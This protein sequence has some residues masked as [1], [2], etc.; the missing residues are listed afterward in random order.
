[1]CRLKD[2]KVDR[3]G[4]FMKNYKT[5][6]QLL[7]ILLFSSS[8]AYA[9]RSTVVTDSGTLK[10]EI[11]ILHRSSELKRFF[12]LENAIS[13]CRLT[14]NY[15]SGILDANGFAKL[16]IS[17][18]VFPDTPIVFGEIGNIPSNLSEIEPH[19]L[20]IVCL[21]GEQNGVR[22]PLFS[23]LEL[24]VIIDANVVTPVTANLYMAEVNVTTTINT[25]G[26]TLNQG[27]YMVKT[28]S[29]LT[30]A[31][32]LNSEAEFAMTYFAEQPAFLLSSDGLTILGNIEQN[33]L[34][35]LYPE[36]TVNFMIS[37]GSMAIIAT[38]SPGAAIETEPG[39]IIDDI[40]DGIT[41]QEIEIN[42]V[43]LTEAG[44][45]VVQ[46]FVNDAIVV[47]DVYVDHNGNTSSGLTNNPGSYTIDNLKLT[48]IRIQV[49][50]HT[51]VDSDVIRVLFIKGGGL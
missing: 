10:L 38:T 19:K 42:V 5:V 33:I 15:A 11:D 7:I 49:P 29:G 28:T 39:L 27:N 35:G 43:D 3:K 26:V 23:T 2:Q 32:V 12:A 45:Y 9:E 50:N 46:M 13:E 48:T 47:H 31:I 1:M 51:Y 34:F 41:G 44:S 37:T 21:G 16:Q 20:I 30:E 25:G 8:Y 4:K 14:M 24:D 40:P 6:V 17:V 22:Q 36:E 18:D